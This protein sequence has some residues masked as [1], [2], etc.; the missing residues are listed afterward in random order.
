MKRRTTII[1]IILGVL[2]GGYF[3]TKSLLSSSPKAEEPSPEAGLSP[4]D[5]TTLPKPEVPP[6]ET[7]VL[8][9]NPETIN[10]F[11]GG[12]GDAYADPTEDAKKTFPKG[13]KFTIFTDNGQV[14]LNNFFNNLAGYYPELE[15]AL[16]TQNNRYTLEY[17]R[18]ENR[19]SLTVSPMF[20]VS[21]MEDI[22]ADV[23]TAL[24]VD[25]TSLCKLKINFLVAYDEVEIEDF[26]ALPLC[27][28]VVK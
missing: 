5:I 6:G 21:D 2:V 19:F 10:I 8:P 11:W 26:G 9:G 3:L 4:T 25:G 28:S 12:Y 18:T 1:L 22:Q 16:I 24:G 17:F 27:S 23:Q 7:T 20:V 14:D 15:A 13:N